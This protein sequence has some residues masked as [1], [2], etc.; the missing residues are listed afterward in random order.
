MEG[1]VA[2]S[3]FVVMLIY[4]INSPKEEMYLLHGTASV[5]WRI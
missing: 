5:E 4:E 2:S 3:G 1:M